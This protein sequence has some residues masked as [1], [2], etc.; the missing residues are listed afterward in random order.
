MAREHEESVARGLKMLEETGMAGGIVNEKDA[1]PVQMLEEESAK[2]FM[3]SD[4]GEWMWA[5][6]GGRKG[7][8]AE[9]GYCI[10]V[11][12]TVLLLECFINSL[13]IRC[14]C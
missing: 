11:I 6:P 9:W 13:M 1:E 12:L 4:V 8:A 14:D 3:Q 10:C 7:A 2:T 5:K